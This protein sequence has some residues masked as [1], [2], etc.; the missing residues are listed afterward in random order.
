[1]APDEQACL[2]RIFLSETSRVDGRLAHEAIVYEALRLKLAGA[3]VLRGVLGFGASAHLHSA[4]VLSLSDSLPLVVEIV[5]RQ[6]N[7]DRLLPFIE[8]NVTTGL[9]TMEKARI[10][11]HRGL[12]SRKDSD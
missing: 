1:M 9:V 2:L 6:E 11:G 4:Q 10:I 7:I 5:D 8:K 12:T 3:T